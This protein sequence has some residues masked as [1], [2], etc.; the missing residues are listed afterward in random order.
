MGRAVE[1][2]EVKRKSLVEDEVDDEVVDLGR[3]FANLTSGESS[4]HLFLPPSLP[5]SLSL[6]LSGKRHGEPQNECNVCVSDPTTFPSLTPST[7]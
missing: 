5:P 2:K 4:T 1:K 6:H 7:I 3:G